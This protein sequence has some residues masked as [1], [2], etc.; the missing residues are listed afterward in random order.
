MHNLD[1]HLCKSTL[2]KIILAAGL[3]VMLVLPASIAGQARESNSTA[4]AA[5][6]LAGGGSH[7]CALMDGTVRCWGYRSM[8]GSARTTDSPVPVAVS[9]LPAGI[10]QISASSDHTC[11]LTSTG[12]VMCWGRNTNGQIGDGT[13]QDRQ[14]PVGV[15]GLAGTVQSIGLGYSHSCAVLASSGAVQCWGLNMNYQL[16][17]DVGSSSDTPVNVSGLSGVGKVV[18]GWAHTCALLT[19][20]AVKCW[21]YNY[22]GSL[23][24]G[25]K[26]DTPVPQNV[27]GL[28]HGVIDVAASNYSTCGLL[29]SGQVKCW[30]LFSDFSSPTPK[31]VTGLESGVIGL[32]LGVEHLCTLHTGGQVRCL[33]NNG[34]GQLGDGTNIGRMS[35]T[36]VPGLESGVTALASGLYHTCA[37]TSGGEV[38]CWGADES[39]QLGIGTT[40][41]ASQ[42][43]PLVALSGQTISSMSNGSNYACAYTTGGALYCWG[44]SN[45]GNLGVAEAIDFSAYALPMPVTG[46]STGTTQVSAGTHTCAVVGGAAKCWG[47]NDAGQLGNGNNSSAYTPSQVSGLT[48]GVSKVA[49]TPFADQAH[50]C[51]IVNEGAQCWGGNYV[52]QL[53]NNQSGV[54]NGVN[55]P[56]AVTGLSSGVSDIAAGGDHSCAVVNG[57]A[58]CWGWAYYGQLGNGVMHTI[59]VPNP[60]Y[61]SPVAVNTLSSGVTAITAGSEF[62]CAVV[63]GAAKCWGRNNAGQLGDGSTTDQS[64]PGSVSGLDSGVTAISAGDTRAC[65]LKSGE[66]WCWG[67]KTDGTGS[68]PY[69]VT[70][71]SGITK[72][73]ASY[74]Y[75]ALNAQGLACWGN[76]YYGQLGDGRIFQSRYAVPVLGFGLQSEVRINTTLAKKGSPLRLV[77]ANFPANATI[78]LKSNGV[79]FCTLTSGPDGFFPAVLLTGGAK[80]GY[81]AISAS[82]GASEATTHFGLMT[83][84]TLHQMEGGGPTCTL[85]GNGIAWNLQF[86]PLINK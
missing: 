4:A 57:A 29:E 31:T 12:G 5:I 71:L 7:T 16:G 46:I 81:Y 21:G 50:T 70:G 62:A 83:G 85:P 3:V 84:A 37:V 39:G 42:P 45:N 26:T 69:K 80:N 11:A 18:A 49:V 6:S 43:W 59:A 82:S 13:N 47:R 73:T 65:A 86:L 30:G 44:L 53:G 33:G 24:N 60:I 34:E 55:T 28:D 2:R 63:G 52:G 20:G 22:Y 51:A 78:T 23:G 58:W 32:A 75:C 10:Q 25:T 72:M 56:Q 66:M 1:R 15:S 68:M 76:D 61:P 38:W 35:P 19:N 36:V 14:T 27:V 54:I 79:N 74:G 41:S 8:V 77:G 48:S 17:A 67:G 64:T 40:T 9:G